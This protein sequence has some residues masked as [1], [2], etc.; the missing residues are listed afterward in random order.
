LTGTTDNGLITYDG[1][2]TN[3]GVVES[4]MTYDGVTRV[5]T[6][7]GSADLYVATRIRPTTFNGLSAPG[8]ISPLAGTLAVS[9]STFGEA[10]VFHNG[11][12]WVKVAGT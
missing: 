6:I 9:S 2:V 1:V 4:S 12:G 7:S 3:A 10:L 11:A 5:L 8:F